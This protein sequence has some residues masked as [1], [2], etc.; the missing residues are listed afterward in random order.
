MPRWQQCVDA[1]QLCEQYRP[2]S[3]ATLSPRAR[4]RHKA[5]RGLVASSANWRVP[6]W[7]DVRTYQKRLA[8]ALHAW[9]LRVSAPL[10]ATRRFADRAEAILPDISDRPPGP[11]RRK[12]RL[13]SEF[14]GAHEALISDDKV[15]GRVWGC[16]MFTLWAVMEQSFLDCAAS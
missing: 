10:A 13:L 9:A 6:V 3:L 12:E 11:W 4:D 5:G 14:A 16:P 15:P 1:P 8:E 2:E 7:S